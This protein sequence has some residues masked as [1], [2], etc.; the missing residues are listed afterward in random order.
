MCEVLDFLRSNSNS[1]DKNGEVE[2]LKEK[3]RYPYQRN[4]VIIIR[5]YNNYNTLSLI[6][7]STCAGYLQVYSITSYVTEQS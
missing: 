1:H 2:V 7:V 6:H 5:K 3:Y 4:N